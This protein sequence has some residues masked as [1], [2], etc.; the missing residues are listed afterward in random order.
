MGLATRL[1]LP[2]NFCRQCQA[3]HSSYSLSHG[4][5]CKLAC[6]QVKRNET[7]HC[8]NDLQ[9]EA[10]ELHLRYSEFCSRYP[11]FVITSLHLLLQSHGSCI[12]NPFAQLTGPPKILRNSLPV[13]EPRIPNHVSTFEL[14]S[15]AKASARGFSYGWCTTRRRL[16]GTSTETKTTG[17]LQPA[18]CC[19][20][21]TPVSTSPR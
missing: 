20:L 18:T 2:A 4:S 5:L 15:C 10:T 3:L 9:Q 1:G 17:T 8:A 21:Q 6:E 13:S 19:T 7:I 16:H 12:R 14:N 11:A